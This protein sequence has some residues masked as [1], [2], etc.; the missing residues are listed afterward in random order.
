[1]SETKRRPVDLVM[2]LWGLLM[3][4]ALG[5]FLQH[6]FQLRQA[7]LFFTG[8]GLGFA[9]LQGMFG[10]TGGWRKFIRERDSVGLRGQLLLVM[11][12]AALFFP[13]V[14]GAIEGVQVS[15]AM[16]QVGISL[17][18]GAFLFGIGMQLGGGCGSGTLFT[19][20]Q[21]QVDMLITLAF[22]II[23]TTLGSAHLGWWL[24]LPNMGSVSLIEQW[25]WAPALLLSLAALVMLYV[26]V[27]REEYRSSGA[28]HSLQNTERQGSLL[29]QLVYGPWPLWWAVIALATLG[30]A[31]LLLAGYPWSITFGFGLWGSKIWAALGG[32]PAGWAYW[33]SGY[34]AKALESSVLADATSVMN[35][36]IMLGALLAAALAGK[37]APAG[38]ISRMRLVSAVAG[39]LL[40]GYGARLAFGCNIGALLGGIASGSLHGWLWMVMAFIGGIAGVKI[41]I[42]MKLDKPL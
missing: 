21:G 30:L 6:E 25:G 20:G 31:T 37:Y 34:P 2:V 16:G 36:G 41:R 12:S 13:L 28:V 1:M 7:L 4:V 17:L 26:V 9:L 15:G 32:D 24:S 39:G 22:F 35:F 18:V 42:W 10:F 38:R 3:A 5:L 14:G 19:V 23:G 33:A 40:L 29:E 27:R 8:L 11:L